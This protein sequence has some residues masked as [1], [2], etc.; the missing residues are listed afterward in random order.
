MRIFNEGKTKEIQYNDIDF[1]QYKLTEDK[2]FI[3]HH[4]AVK[5]V[6]EKFHREIVAKYTNGGMDV[7]KVVDVPYAAPQEAWD[8]YEDILCAV[9]LTDEEY[10]ERVR[11]LREL[12]C[13]PIINRGTLWYNT[14]SSK[15]MQELDQ[16]YKAWLDVTKTKQI[17]VKPSWLE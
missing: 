12:Q 7:K 6:K 4:K 11:N 17:P 3:K 15:Q 2:L 13:F 8:E 14:L 16:W 5:E 1:L 10:N 9:P